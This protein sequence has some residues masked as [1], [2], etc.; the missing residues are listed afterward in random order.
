MINSALGFSAVEGAG[1]AAG[2]GSCAET[3]AV[4]TSQEKMIAQRHAKL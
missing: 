2:V 3:T 4:E 1:V